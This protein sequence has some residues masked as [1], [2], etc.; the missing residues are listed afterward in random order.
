M[1]EQVLS[2]HIGALSAQLTPQA[3]PL[4]VGTWRM[5][6]AMQ[7]AHD[8]PHELTLVGSPH[9][10]SLDPSL[11]PGASIGFDLT[12]PQ[13]SRTRLHRTSERIVRS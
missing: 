9:R 10:A 4:Q 12:L 6:L 8:A 3:V 5:P 13:P 1:R 11:D 7:T 2:L